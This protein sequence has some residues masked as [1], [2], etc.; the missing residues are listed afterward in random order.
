MG[1]AFRREDER[2]ALRATARRFGRGEVA[3]VA[4]ALATEATF[5]R[6]SIRKAWELG[7]VHTSV[8][9]SCGG[10]AAAG[11]VERVDARRVALCIEVLVDGEIPSY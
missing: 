2:I 9:D 4:G 11:S 8:P 6:E 5:P 7:L 3:P 10:L 1:V